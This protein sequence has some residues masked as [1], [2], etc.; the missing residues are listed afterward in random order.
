MSTQDGTSNSYVTVIVGQLKASFSKKYLNEQ[1]N[2][3]Q[4]LK[5]IQYNVEIQNLVKIVKT[6]YYHENMDFCA[7]IAEVVDEKVR[8]TLGERFILQVYNRKGKI[9]YQR[10]IKYDLISWGIFHSYF[11]YKLD[12]RE[13]DSHNLHIVWLDKKAAVMKIKDFA[14]NDTYNYLGINNECFYYGN[15]SNIKIIDIK[16]GIND[17][18]V[19]EFEVPEAAIINYDIPAPNR[20]HGFFEN[21]F[22]KI[23]QYIMCMIETD[24]NQFDFN[25]L[26]F[27][28]R[29]FN[30]PSLEFY[31]YRE[32]VP[33]ELRK[34]PIK[35]FTQIIK[36]NEFQFGVAI[37]QSGQADFYWNFSLVSSSNEKELFDDCT[38]NF[39]FLYLKQTYSN[40]IFSIELIHD[41]RVGVDVATNY[42]YEDP[43][44]HSRQYGLIKDHVRIFTGYTLAN[45]QFFVSYLNFVSV[46]DVITKQ[47]IQHFE[48]NSRCMKLF[49]TEKSDYGSGVNNDSSQGLV[50]VHLENGEIAIIEIDKDEE[51]GNDRYTLRD[52]RDKLPGRIISIVSDTR[53][54][55]SHFILA[56][57]NEKK[58]L[59]GLKQD[60]A[61]DVSKSVKI[62][63]RSNLIKFISKNNQED[64]AVFNY[65]DGKLVTYLN[66]PSIDSSFQMVE[67]TEYSISNFYVISEGLHTVV[68]SPDE[69][70][71]IMVDK[72]NIYKFDIQSSTITNTVQEQNI[73]N[74]QVIDEKYIYALMNKSKKM[75]RVAG[76]YFMNIES[77]LEGSDEANTFRMKNALVGQ[78][79]ILSYYRQDERLGYMTDYESVKIVPVLHRNT[80]SFFGIKKKS[81]YVCF[82]KHNDKL[83]GLDTDNVLSTFSIATGKILKRV[84]L[85]KPIFTSTMKIWACDSTD[86]TYMKDYYFPRV[87]VYDTTPV[88]INEDD[89]FGER[90]KCDLDNCTAYTGMLEK[91]F[92]KFSVLEIINES[93]VKVCYSFIHVIIKTE[94]FQKIYLSDDLEYMIERLQNQRVFLFR[95]VKLADGLNKMVIVRRIKQFPKDISDFSSYNYLFSPNLQFY[96]DLDVNDNC[97]Q[98][99]RTIDQTVYQEI[100]KGLL[101]SDDTNMIARKFTWI[102]NYKVR[103]INIEG[104]EKVLDVHNKMEQLSYGTVPMLTHN[105]FTDKNDDGV[106]NDKDTGHYFYDQKKVEIYEIEK[107]LRLKYQDYFRAYFVDNKKQPEQ[108]YDCLFKVDFEQE[109]PMADLSFS[110]FHW[111]LA[112]ML[113]D[114]KK[115]IKVKQIN[116]NE[117]KLLLLNIFPLGNTVLHLAIR[118][119]GAI[120][121]F[122]QIIRDSNSE[123]EKFEIPFI[124]NFNNETPIHLCLKTK[125]FKSADIILQNLIDSPLDSH[126]RGILDILPDLVE[127]DIPCLKD[128]LDGRFIQTDQIKAIRRGSINYAFGNDEYA[129]QSCEL[130]PDRLAVEEKLF[131]KSQL[132]SEIKLEFL[133]IPTIHSF[134]GKNGQAFF[135]S[136]AG[137]S[138]MDLFACRSVQALIDYKWPLVREYT[139]KI[140]FVPFIFYQ[141][142]WIIYSNVFNGQMDESP[143]DLDITEKVI[144][145][146]LY[147]FSIYFLFNE[148]RQIINQGF[149]YLLSAW[150]YTDLLPPVFIITVIS[151]HIVIYLKEKNDSAYDPNN[152]IETIHSVASLLMWAKLLYFLR[153]FYSTGYLIRMISNVVW[154]MKIFLLILFLM[155]FGFGEAFL[156]LSEA[157][158]G[159]DDEGNEISFI[160]NYAMCWVYAYR[161]SMGDGSTDTFNKTVQ[162]VTLWILWCI[163]LLLTNIVMLNMLIA[164]IGE[165]FNQVNSMQKQASYQERSK[166][167]AENGYLIPMYR[168]K[169][170]N[171]QLNYIITAMEITEQ[172]EADP[173]KLVDQF[174]SI[175]ESLNKFVSSNCLFNLTLLQKTEVTEKNKSLEDKIEKIFAKFQK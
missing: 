39:D 102:D 73:A 28:D 23:D 141:A 60:K 83:T 140:L 143:E 75:K 136:L 172:E 49:R 2:P 6:C 41:T 1:C 137:C 171:D 46:Y 12:R 165:S 87:L 95:R 86:K 37:R 80:I 118:N 66:L 57:V 58:T 63:D 93:E 94:P 125:N 16:K 52:Q 97:F 123:S 71:L 69:K 159:Q 127:A 111:K 88:E 48:F 76:F 21:G 25:R 158:A 144:I 116:Q 70:Y 138:N 47:F 101:N 104:V 133:D 167:I 162:P 145:A 132:D 7:I 106:I 11:V 113:A 68:V 110:Y 161:L 168:K 107:K 175:E 124:N 84:K 19:M 122:Y 150:N 10:Y 147:V 139:I 3:K 4:F 79:T 112:E 146:L 64:F 15:P 40:L 169:E 44:W 148:S 121:K 61:T 50:L 117:I 109:K 92:H 43:Y 131:T 157:S 62:T 53:D 149:R 17:E 26:Y 65:D 129:V 72:T 29:D 20:L 153:I 173:S 31:Q 99:K 42:L 74:L 55:A 59:Y 166:I 78:M 103:I 163:C 108:L 82:R 14:P 174:Q 135:N 56:E 126:I 22:S 164:I 35:K 100:P 105:D 85:R 32:V 128:Y 8:K 77:I 134:A 91:S 51:T 13:G 119:L 156:R 130:W 9:V 90:L 96:L 54:Y 120:R 36:A 160:K 30:N 142:L 38:S 33:R 98:I 155:Y 67:N 114:P 151:L 170:L 89:Y 115:K 154:D 24:D 18:Q 45:I 27:W 81:H 34:D 5:N 152:F